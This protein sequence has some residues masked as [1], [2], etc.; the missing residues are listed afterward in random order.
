M[1]EVEIKHKIAVAIASR[2]MTKDGINESTEIIYKL[3]NELLII[4]RVTQQ[5]ELFDAVLD[6]SEELPMCTEDYHRSELW[7]RYKALNCG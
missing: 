3:L 1:T 4:Q 2:Q 6:F 7:K 5:R